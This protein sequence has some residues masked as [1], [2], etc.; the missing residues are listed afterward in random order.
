MPVFPRGFSD[1]GWIIRYARQ[2][3]YDIPT[4]SYIHGGHVAAKNKANY[5]YVCLKPI[6][7][8]IHFIIK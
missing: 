8:R 3:I 5:F 7:T 6:F 1:Y 2:I 4:L